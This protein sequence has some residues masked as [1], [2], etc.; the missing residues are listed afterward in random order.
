MDPNEH[1][2]HRAMVSL[3]FSVEQVEILRPKI[4]KIADDI[5]LIK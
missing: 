3:N 2:R 1:T 4:Q 5:S